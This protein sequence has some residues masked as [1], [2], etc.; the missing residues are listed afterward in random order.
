MPNKSNRFA[1]LESKGDVTSFTFDGRCIR[2]RSPKS[3]ERYSSIKDWDNGYLVVEALYRGFS[4]PVEDY[5]DLVPILENL[6]IDPV[7]FCEPIEGVVLSA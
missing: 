4:D 6:F 2:F 3:L 7:A 1:L 5:I